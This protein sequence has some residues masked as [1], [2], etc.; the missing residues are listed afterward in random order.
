MSSLLSD[1][2]LMLL[3]NRQKRPHHNDDDAW[4]PVSLPDRDF[5]GPAGPDFGGLHFDSMQFWTERWYRVPYSRTEEWYEEERHHFLKSVDADMSSSHDHWEEMTGI[6]RTQTCHRLQWVD[7]QHQTCNLFHE[8]HLGREPVV[9]PLPSTTAADGE[10]HHHHG[11]RHRNHKHPGI[12]V[13]QPYSRR[14]LSHGYFRDSW[15]W[16][17]VHSRVISGG[18]SHSSDSPRKGVHAASSASASAS[19]RLGQENFVL[20][21]LRLTN[22]DLDY[23][24]WTAHHM[25]KEALVMER[26][27]A[28]PRTMNIYGHCYT[29][30]LV[31]QGFEI[32]QRIVQGIEYRGRGRIKQEDL[33]AL[34]ANGTLASFNEFSAEEKLEIATAMAEAIAEMHGNAEGVIV[35]DDVHPDQFLVN[36][37]GQVKF[38]DMNNAHILEWNPA[39]S[40]YCKW[41]IWIGG[42]YRSPEEMRGEPID[43]KSDVWPMGALIFGLLTGLFPYYTVW[44]TKAV[45]KVIASGEPPYLDPRWKNKSYIE[46]RMVEIMERCF[47]DKPEDRASIF[48]V[49]LSLRETAEDVVVLR[50][51]GKVDW[52]T[53]PAGLVPEVSIP[54]PE[55]EMPDDDGSG[56]D[57]DDRDGNNHDRHSP[58]D[59]GLSKESW[60]GLSERVSR[61]ESSS[62]TDR[63]TAVNA[64]DTSIHLVDDDSLEALSAS[65]IRAGMGAKKQDEEHPEGVQHHDDGKP[66]AETVRDDHVGEEQ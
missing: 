10:D 30:H 16:E 48:E 56:D 35:N 46:G 9:G 47:A 28:S 8:L 4:V 53:K 27:T 64:Y 33:D 15:L 49:V 36:R 32:S 3:Q 5:F 62:G 26:T 24:W 44:D 18:D 54:S 22:S 20:K 14:Y 25:F 58:E 42:D 61:V 23:G 12:D 39:N 55:Y 29:S 66:A 65:S 31:E 7:T 19:S 43:E 60:A 17:P 11:H 37:H 52:S 1:G 21:A 13:T 57:G 45:E 59:T 41:P 34:Q 63:D 38:N 6:D 40:S 2:M 51:Q 50:S